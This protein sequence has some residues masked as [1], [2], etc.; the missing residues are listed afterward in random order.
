MIRLTAIS[1]FWLGLVTSLQA[2][3]P[4][5][6]GGDAKYWVVLAVVFILF[7]GIIGLLFALERRL[8]RL[9]GQAD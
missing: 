3:S 1:L 6:G 5:Y 8:K 9:E 7:V 4:A 2:Q